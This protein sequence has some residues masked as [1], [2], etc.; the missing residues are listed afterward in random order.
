M[1]YEYRFA[2][3]DSGAQACHDCVNFNY[4]WKEKMLIIEKDPDLSRWMLYIDQMYVENC[5]PTV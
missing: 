3:F 4:Q 2:G 5:H 1:L